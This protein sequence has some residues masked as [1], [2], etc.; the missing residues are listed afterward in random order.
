MRKRTIHLFIFLFLLASCAPQAQTSEVSETS[1]VL[2]TPPPTLTPI[3]TPTVHPQI[4]AVRERLAQSETYSLNSDGEIEMQTEE[5]VKVIPDLSVDINGQTTLTIDG[6]TYEVDE[7]TIKMNDQTFSF[8]TENGKTWVFD[9]ENWED[10]TAEV[11]LAEDMKIFNL[12]LDDYKITYDAEGKIELRNKSN[13]LVYWDGKW[14]SKEIANI[15]RRAE[16]C[17]PTEFV[18]SSQMP[19]EWN[20]YTWSIFHTVRKTDRFKTVNT[21]P[22]YDELGYFNYDPI[23]SPLRDSDNC[24]IVFVLPINPKQPINYVAFETADSQIIG[25]PLF[26]P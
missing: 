5:G 17:K 14:N 1:E 12:S 25:V 26:T 20:E 2:P 23:P 15:I 19:P 10:R 21:R 7:T 24:W 16:I 11:Q 6:E 22:L 18:V 9:G 4:I 3:P 8:K 13:K